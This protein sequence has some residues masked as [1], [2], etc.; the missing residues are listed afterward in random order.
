MMLG[1]GTA[2]RRRLLSCCP[3][4]SASRRGQYI[5]APRRKSGMYCAGSLSFQPSKLAR[6]AAVWPRAAS[7][8]EM[9]GL[10]QGRRP[11]HHRL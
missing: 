5:E 11:R 8:G 7:A 4:V 2:S 1:V 3:W 10:C 6:I 9:G